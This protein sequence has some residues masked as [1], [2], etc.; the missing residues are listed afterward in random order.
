MY[1]RLA[2]A[3]AAH[4]E[5]EILLVDEVLAVGDLAFQQKCLGK[6]G[7]VT[8]AGRTVLFVS[9]NLAPVQR[10]CQRG[11]V[12]EAGRLA[13]DG[14]VAGALAHYLQAVQ[15][16]HSAGLR[17]RTDRLGDGALRFTAVRFRGPAG[18]AGVF[19]TG[20]DF[21]AELDYEAARPPRHVWACVPF[22][23]PLGQPVFMTWTRVGGADFAV[24]PPRGTIV[25]EIPRLPLRAGAYTLNLYA[26]VDGRMADCVREAAAF[27]VA[28]GDY[29]GTGH[30]PPPGYGQVVVDH[31]F[32]L[33]ECS[34]PGVENIERCHSKRSEES[35]CTCGKLLRCAQHDAT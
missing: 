31:R 13:F 21:Q 32:H 7:D 4:L 27:Q 35:G 5:P 1:V 19:L 33:R 8:R 12:L 2:F 14:P 10:L 26:E 18:P 30:L 15:P 9:H 24:L 17:A 11:I 29:Y 16:A 23:A 3:V 25:L 6:L 20:E 34:S 22:F 28:D